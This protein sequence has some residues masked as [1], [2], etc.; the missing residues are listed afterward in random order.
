MA[1][2]VSVSDLEFLRRLDE[3]NRLARRLEYR[4]K[5]MGT[6][7]RFRVRLARATDPVTCAR[8]ER[9]EYVV[10]ARLLVENT[11]L[12]LNRV[13][14]HEVMMFGEDH[15]VKKVTADL[16]SQLVTYL[17]RPNTIPAQE[18]EDGASKKV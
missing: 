13:L 11:L 5:A 10:E 9:G 1:E 2:A 6:L 16:V 3:Y 8:V 7:L 18:V 12:R 14:D 4:L 17:V 15:A